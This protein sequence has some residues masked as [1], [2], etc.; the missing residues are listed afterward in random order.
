VLLTLEEEDGYLEAATSVGRQIDTAYQRALAGI[1]ATI[2]GEQPVKPDAYLLLHVSVVLLGSGLRPEECYRLRWEQIQDDGI[3]ISTGKGKGSKRRVPVLPAFGPCSICAVPEP[4]R[5]G[6]FRPPPRATTSKDLLSRKQ[7]EDAIGAS[8]VTR[9]VV[10]DL[11]HTRRT[12]W[13]KILPLPVVQR[14][15]GHT[16]ISN[17]MR[18]VHVRDE[19]VREA[20]HKEQEVRSGHTSRHTAQTANKTALKTVM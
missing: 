1:R 12:R 19:D 9:F 2:R 5:N 18:Y 6:C 3:G 8:G 15:A 20:M 7:H 14:L 17:T 10:Y 16:S 13:A 4:I 11:R